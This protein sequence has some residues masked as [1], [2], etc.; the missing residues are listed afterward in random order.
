MNP[1][2]VGSGKSGKTFLDR[3]AIPIGVESRTKVKKG[4][5]WRRV[6]H[7]TAAHVP[8]EGGSQNTKRKVPKG[9]E[10][11]REI[12]LSGKIWKRIERMVRAARD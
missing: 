9:G 1:S 12:S 2:P 3:N 5:L 8:N 11:G 7:R 6:F 10:E 4:G